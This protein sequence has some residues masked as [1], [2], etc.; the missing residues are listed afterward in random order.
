MY[1]YCGE[2]K[3]RMSIRRTKRRWST[4]TSACVYNCMLLGL[5]VDTSGL[6][7]E[8]QTQQRPGQRVSESQGIRE[9]ENRR[10]T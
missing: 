10:I 1:M 3:Y 7:I 8:K 9:S 2:R 6:E 5:L 4:S